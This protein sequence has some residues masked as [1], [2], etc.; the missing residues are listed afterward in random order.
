MVYKYSL[1][2]MVNKITVYRGSEVLRATNCPIC[3][4]RIACLVP[5]VYCA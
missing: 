5:K 2:E 4:E 3:K 1:L